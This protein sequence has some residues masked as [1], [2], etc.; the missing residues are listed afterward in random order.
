MAYKYTIVEQRN[1][2]TGKR[3][4]YT[5][6]ETEY[7][8]TDFVT[9]EQGNHRFNSLRSMKKAIGGHASKHDWEHVSR[10]ETCGHCCCD[11]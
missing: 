2:H 11:C 3:R 1:N 6:W 7:G 8:A 5:M 9:G 10:T 4:W